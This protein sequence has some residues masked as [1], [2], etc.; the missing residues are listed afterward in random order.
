M[1]ELL[2][3]GKYTARTA[4]A[5]ADITATQQLRHRCFVSGQDRAGDREA[6]DFDTRCIHILVEHG[7][8]GDLVCCFRL[9]PLDHP[10]DIEQSYSAQFYDLSALTAYTGTMLEVGR[11]CIAPSAVDPDILRV[12]WGALTRYVDERGVAFLFGCSS[13]HGTDAARY[14]DTFEVLAERH[15]APHTWVPQVRATQVV[16]FARD[17][18]ARPVD[19]KAAMLRMPPLL[20]TYLRMGG[21]VSDHAVIDEELGTLHVFTGLEIAAIPQARAKA[22]RA[23][24]V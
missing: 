19:R 24:A 18:L 12:A 10:R 4:R 23:V 11:F 21:W 5:E 20:K 3:R 17:R 15:L 16:H 6:D 7:A 14:H 9:L 13:F 22:L 8:S 1:S 2:T